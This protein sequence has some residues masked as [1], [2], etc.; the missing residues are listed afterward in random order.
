[1]QLLYAAVPVPPRCLDG[2][3]WERP[4][5][6]LASEPFWPQERPGSSV[7]FLEELQVAADAAHGSPGNRPG[8]PAFRRTWFGQRQRTNYPVQRAPG[9]HPGGS[10]AHGVPSGSC[11]WEVA[12]SLLPQQVLD[13]VRI[14][15]SRAAPTGTAGR[16]GADPNAAPLLSVNSHHQSFEIEDLQAGITS[17]LA[18]QSKC[19]KLR[20]F[21]QRGEA[22]AVNLL[23]PAGSRSSN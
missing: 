9:I 15:G 10:E 8:M 11:H 2:E 12:S 23:S 22:R 13:G 3:A 6:L 17:F 21:P 14:A 18:S 1:M 19:R 5:S 16:D 4:A 7:D 20:P